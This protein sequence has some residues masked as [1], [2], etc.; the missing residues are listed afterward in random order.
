MAVEELW[1]EY[2]LEVYQGERGDVCLHAV[3]RSLLPSDHPATDQNILEGKKRTKP[4][5]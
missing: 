2:H 1:A 3:R 5:V 4:T